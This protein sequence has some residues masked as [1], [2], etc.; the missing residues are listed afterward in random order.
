MIPQERPE[1]PALGLSSTRI[2]NR[3]PGFVHEQKARGEQLFS[4]DLVDW[5]ELLGRYPDPVRQHRSMDLDPL[6]AHRFSLAIQGRV[7]SVFGHQHLGD[8]SL[9]RQSALHQASWRRGLHDRAFALPAGVFWPTRHQDPV[10]DRLNIETLRDRLIDLMHA[11]FAAGAES[12]FRRNHHLNDRKIFWKRGT[13]FRASALTRLLAADRRDFI[14]RVL[15]PGDGLLDVFQRQLQLVGVKLFGGAPEL[16]ALVIDYKLD[17]VL[18]DRL[19]FSIASGKFIVPATDQPKG[20][21]QRRHI[22]RKIVQIRCH[23]KD[24]SIVRRA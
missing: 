8:E 23:A 6:P 20:G 1:V 15:R 5:R 21:A 19:K 10:L 13:L 3:R 24:W 11:L 18:V 17:E 22:L 12:A 7:I 4:H 14:R 2:Q 9:G 16:Q